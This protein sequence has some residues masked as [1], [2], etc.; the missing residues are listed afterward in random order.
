[1]VLAFLL[2]VVVNGETV[3][4]NRMLFQSIY[5]CNE[6]AIA[7]EEGRSSSKNIKKYRMQKNV[8]AYCIPKM[9]SQ[10]TELFE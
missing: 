8:S 3:S 2:V 4:D 9:V 10:K 1:V 5:R 7:I 6:F